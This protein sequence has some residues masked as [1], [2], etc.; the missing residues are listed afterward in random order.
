MTSRLFDPVTLGSLTLANRIVMA[1]MTRSRADV[2]DC[3]TDLHVEYYWQRASAGMI[4]T[5]GIQPSAVGKGYARTPGLYN[6]RQVTAWRRVTDAVHAEGGQIVAQL[7]H[8]GRIAAAANRDRLDVIAPSAIKARA[9]LWTVDG[10]AP[11]EEPRALETAEIADVIEEYAAAATRAISAGF[12]GVELHCTSGYLPAQFMATGTNQRTDRYGGTRENRVRFVVETLEALAGA[13]GSG[14][15]GFRICPG[16]PFNDLRDNDPTETHAALL[17]AVVGFDLAYCHLIEMV[18]PQA[19]DH[20]ALLASHWR[21]GIVLNESIDQPKAE[22]LVAD[23]AADAIA[24]G[25]PFI[26]NPDLVDRFRHGYPLSV[27]EGDNIYAGGAKGY[28]DY[29]AYQRENVTP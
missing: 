26:A 1:P 25:R 27:M 17:D 21:G 16:N 12:D 7:M 4:V 8:V 10:M 15:V 5:E 29:P 19:V 14:R 2:H 11:T 22:Q 28:T 3:P 6:E 23:G 24:F 9:K 20:R 18:T 13:I